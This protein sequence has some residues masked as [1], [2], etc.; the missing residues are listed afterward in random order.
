MVS[1][2][3]CLLIIYCRVPLVWLHNSFVCCL[4]HSIC[5]SSA[6]QDEAFGLSNAASSNAASQEPSSEEA[7]HYDWTLDDEQEQQL[8]IDDSPPTPTFRTT[9]FDFNFADKQSIRANLR[10][11]SKYTPFFNGTILLEGENRRK[12]DRFASECTK[13]RCVLEG[14]LPDAHSLALRLSEAQR[15]FGMNGEVE[16]EAVELLYR[17]LEMHLKNVLAPITTITTSSSAH[18][19]DATA[20]QPETRILTAAQIKQALEVKPSVFGE[21]SVSLEYFNL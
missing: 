12:Y 21:D 10:T 3:F 17:G 16:A 6:G 2:W 11:H 20:D 4:Y 15:L 13:G 1:Y 5:T 19:N 9:N 18:L 8:E 14:D 7:K